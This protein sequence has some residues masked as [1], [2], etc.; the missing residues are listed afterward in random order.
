MNID[1]L[2]YFSVI[3]ETKNLRKASELI[4][5]TPGSLSKAISVLE[6][7]LSIKLLRPEGRGIEITEEGLEIYKKSLSLLN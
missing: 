3:V 4:G 7:E 5:I 2:K 1:R 6:S